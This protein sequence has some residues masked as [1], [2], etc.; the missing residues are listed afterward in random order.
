MPFDRAFKGHSLD[1]LRAFFN[2]SYEVDDATGEADWT[3]RLL[4]EF[5]KRRGYD[6][7]QHLPQL[8]GK[9]TDEISARVLAD[10]RETISDLLLD[11]FTTE[12]ASWA[13]RHGRQVRNQ[14]HGSPA[15]ILDLYAASDLPETE[16]AEIQRFKWATSAAH[17]AGRRLVS[18]EAGTW[19]GE[20]FRVRLAEVKPAVDQFFVAGVN[21]IV[22]HGTGA[23][24]PWAIRG[25]AAR[26]RFGVLPRRGRPHPRVR[27]TE[28]ADDSV[29]LHPAAHGRDAGRLSAGQGRVRDWRPP[30]TPLAAEIGAASATCG[31]R[32]SCR[33]G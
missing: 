3:P 1:G 25:P 21:H 8:L 20:H 29:A 17:V 32:P 28:R 18:A 4:E 7:R 5:E 10:Y 15:S 9:G 13:R 24:H 26:S 27:C 12:W 11:T 22:Y 6:L 2:D 23:T 31:T 19:L 30:G 14:A 16:G 33:R